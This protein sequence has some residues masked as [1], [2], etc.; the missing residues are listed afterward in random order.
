[1]VSKLKAGRTGLFSL[2]LGLVAAGPSLAGVV[3]SQDPNLNAFRVFSQDGRQQAFDDFRLAAPAAIT[4]IEWWGSA[5]TNRLV[6]PV[7]TDAG[8]ASPLNFTI[9]IYEND[10][11]PFFGVNY[12]YANIF[13][14]AI[15]EVEAQVQWESLGPTGPFSFPVQRYTFNL[16]TALNLPAN[17]TL[18]ISVLAKDVFFSDWS[19]QRAV[20]RPTD[21]FPVYNTYD[22]ASGNLNIN[23]GDPQGHDLAFRLSTTDAPPPI[24]EP[25]TLALIG[26]GVFGLAA[27][28]RR[29]RR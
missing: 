25:A 13:I 8:L 12:P 5:I 19:W 28:R 23:V 16:P 29:R 15:Y 6:G 20:A 14:P 2:A 11:F 22:F 24:P 17:Q 18:W 4:R 10:V 1:M 27:V 21:P 26:A 9:A 7:F 3:Y